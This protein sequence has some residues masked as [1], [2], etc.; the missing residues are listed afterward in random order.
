MTRLE[1]IYG[2]WYRFL[3]LNDKYKG[4]DKIAPIKNNWKIPTEF[5]LSEF[6]DQVLLRKKWLNLAKQTFLEDIRAFL[7]QYNIELSNSEIASLIK[8][9]E[10]RYV[11]SWFYRVLVD[12]KKL[13]NNCDTFNVEFEKFYKSS[14]IC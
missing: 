13:F 14:K 1:R 5:T 9:Y 3:K 8:A 12:S 11:Y 6:Y 10:D 4:F 7:I 2:L